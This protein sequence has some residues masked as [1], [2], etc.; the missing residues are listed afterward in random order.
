MKRTSRRG[1][2]NKCHLCGCNILT[3][4]I[5]GQNR[6]IMLQ[7]SP[8]NILLDE[9]NPDGK[10]YYGGEMVDGRCVPDGLKAYREH[11]CVWV[12]K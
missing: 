12:R 10:F 8:V 2:W 11:K 5:K 7:P 9:R 1:N 6:V 4:R 3:R